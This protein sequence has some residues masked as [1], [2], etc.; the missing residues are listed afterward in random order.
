MMWTLLI[1]TSLVMSLWAQTGVSQCSTNPCFNGGS[2]EDNVDGSYTCHCTEGFV[3]DRCGTSIEVAGICYSNNPCQ[4]GAT[5]F[6]YYNTYTCYCTTGFTG[7]LC[8][9]PTGN[10]NCF[11]D[12]QVYQHFETR[13]EDCNKC[14]C[15]YGSWSCTEI[16]CHSGGCTHDGV[17]YSDGAERQLDCGN[18]CTCLNGQWGCSEL[19]CAPCTHSFVTYSHSATRQQDCNTCTC[20]NGQWNCT[21]LSCGLCPPI[22]PGISGDCTLTACFSDQFCSNNQKCCFNGCV[23]TCL[24]SVS[25]GD[26]CYPNPCH[27]GGTCTITSTSPGYVCLC[28]TG[29]YG[30]LC[31]IG[32][33]PTQCA[34]NPCINGGTCSM[35]NNVMTCTCLSGYY[36]DVCEI[37]QDPCDSMP[38]LNGGTCF[39]AGNGLSAYVCLCASGYTGTNCEGSNGREC[40]YGSTRYNEFATRQEDCNVCECLN[41]GWSCTTNPCSTNPCDSE[42][43]QHDGTCL[44]A[45]TQ[46]M[47]QCTDG[48]TGFNCETLLGGSCDY[49]GACHNGATCTLTQGGMFHCNCAYG[50]SGQYCEIDI[51]QTHQG[52]CPSV[53]EPLD[54]TVGHDCATMC[55]GDYQCEPNEKCCIS[56]NC[57]MQC[58]QVDDACSIGLTCMNGGTCQPIGYTFTCTC[59]DGYTGVYC[60]IAT[61]NLCYTDNPCQNGGM[62]TTLVGSVNVCVCPPT[63]MGKYCEHVKTGCADG[64]EPVACPLDP[65]FLAS[66]PSNLAAQCRPNYCG[67]CKTQFFFDGDIRIQCEDPCSPDPCQNNGV[68]YNINGKTPLCMCADGFYGTHCERILSCDD[69]VEP[70]PCVSNHCDTTLCPAHP[71][72]RCEVNICQHGIYNECFPEFFDEQDNIVDC[73]DMMCPYGPLAFECKLN[74]CLLA[75]CPTY[76][77]ATCVPNYCHVSGCIAEYIDE[78][79]N[80]VDCTDPPKPGQCPPTDGLFG[81]CVELCTLDEN[82]PD[83]Q[84]CCSN[85]CGHTC[86]N[87]ILVPV[88]PCPSGEPLKNEHGVELLCGPNQH[89]CPVGHHCIMSTDNHAVCCP[90]CPDGQLPTQCTTNPCQ[91]SQCASHPNAEC[92]ANYCGGCFAEFYD[93]YGMKVNCND[94]VCSDTIVCY[95]GGLCSHGVCVCADGFFGRL[96]EEYNPCADGKPAK[97]EDGTV[98]FCGN[99]PNHD[100]CPPGHHCKM[101]TGGL[102]VCCP[103]CPDGQQTVQCATNPCRVSQCASNPNAECHANYCG[104]CFA[105]FYDEYGMKVNCDDEKNVCPRGEASMNEDGTNM[106]CSPDTNQCPIEHYCQTFADGPSMCCPGCPDNQQFVQCTAKPCDVTQCAF[107][108]NAICRDNYC[109][110]CFAEFYDANGMNI[111]CDEKRPCTFRDGHDYPHGELLEGSEEDGDCNSCTCSNGVWSCTNIYCGDATSCYYSDMAYKQGEY[112]PNECN[113]CYCNQ[114]EWVCSNRECPNDEELVAVS[115]TFHL[116][117]D[118]GVIADDVDDFEESISKS[119]SLNFQ[120]PDTMIDNMKISEGSIKV[121]FNIVADPEINKDTEAVVYKMEEKISSY[122]FVYNGVI[123]EVD[124]STAVFEKV[125]QEPQPVKRDTVND[126]LIIVGIVIAVVAVLVII[127]VVTYLIA[128]SCNDSKRRSNYKHSTPRDIVHAYDNHAFPNGSP[129][130]SDNLKV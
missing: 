120:I 14:T 21:Q 9:T 46:Y 17:A 34:Y 111:D 88:N 106:A 121:E 100:Q 79:G 24:N 94:I 27:N 68:C 23:V 99:M 72:A 74:P 64:S 48:Y 54:G 42:P 51:S 66:C 90:G 31:N 127:M 102:D 65:C 49:T 3:G 92:H 41:G 80:K 103:G 20:L 4:N 81:T 105:E 15:N 71:N 118:Y 12:G 36:G 115:V 56:F 33:G 19:P 59:P 70:L 96:C 104:G 75:S 76:P 61:D 30:Q 44:H 86:Q 97:D 40:Y 108:P 32:T 45:N 114:K 5:C 28:A 6:G 91:V 109:G 69:G 129:V 98:L 55:I 57:G 77:T 124:G 43:C 10:V 116:K 95:N 113:T 78:Y 101:S 112:R 122:T 119:I 47:C 16:S 126:A 128:S 89:H 123:Y 18:F 87:P 73:L 25:V 93:E 22:Y 117:G 84:K 107:D 62:C 13:Q 52:M 60:E 85:G 35:V 7:T 83:A 2:C 1:M 38:C 125:Y 82:C 67:G 8:D 63:W 110:G 26:S 29:Y 37:V 11:Y 50:F 39:Q 130:G 58:T 53:A